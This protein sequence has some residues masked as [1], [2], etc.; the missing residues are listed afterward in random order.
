MVTVFTPTYNRVHT[1]GKLFN[2]LCAQSCKDFEWVIVD[3]GSKDDTKQLVADFEQ[4]ADFPIRYMRQSNRGKHIAIN[5][6]IKAARG[7]LFFIVDSDDEIP[8]DSIEKV[9]QLYDT[10]RNQES[11][12]GIAGVMKSIDGS[13]IGGRKDYDAI[14]SNS[15]DIRYKHN[16]SGDL[17]EIFK[18]I[19]LREFSFPEYDGEKFC[20]EALV[21]NR[22]ATQYKL[23]FTSEPL[24]IREYLPDGLT[25]K[26]VRIRREAPMGSMTYYSELRGYDIPFVQ[27]V[28]ASINF[29]RFAPLRLYGKARS[30]GMI[31]FWSLMS[32]PL[33]VA[34]RLNDARR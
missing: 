1:L 14:D 25:A 34:M 11:Y 7:E 10:I 5:T 30:M 31:N 15:I 33:G 9:C 23:R 16:V 18:T 32:W 8:D 12:G 13:I 22:I 6:G 4:S 3:D 24:C 29:W 20:P 2:S 26:I 19:V 27:K 28:K 21:W 17:C